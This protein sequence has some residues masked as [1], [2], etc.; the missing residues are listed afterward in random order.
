M[1]EL[2]SPISVTFEVTPKCGLDCFFCSQRLT[3]HTGPEYLKN[4]LT[5]EEILRTVDKLGDANL[6]DILI[7]GGEPLSRKDL[8][9][10]IRRCKGYGIYTEVVTNAHHAS[11]KMSY[12]LADAGLE[13]IQVSLEGTEEIHD[14]ITNRPGSY[15]R[16]M[17]GIRNLKGHMDVVLSSVVTMQNYRALPQLLEMIGQEELITSYRTLRLMPLSREILSQVVPP[18][19][20]KEINKEIIRIGEKYNIELMDLYCGLE[21]TK[22]QTLHSQNVCRAGKTEF[23]ILSDGTVVPCIGFRGKELAF[24]NI[25]EDEIEDL[26]NH[27]IMKE[28]RELRPNKY[29]GECGRCSSKDTCYSCRAIAYN[30]TGSIYGD[31]VSCYDLLEKNLFST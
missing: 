5:T 7:T 20:I 10:V 15:R 8:P 16:T 17:E 23:S 14:R 2:S 9:L 25:L 12:D 13:W 24:G 18:K 19:D 26:W 4:M 28:F 30:L 3:G 11:E 27:P 1:V 29:D 6:L 22:R 21:K 31:D